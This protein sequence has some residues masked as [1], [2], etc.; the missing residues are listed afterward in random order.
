MGICSEPIGIDAENDDMIKVTI[1]I[2]LFQDDTH[3]NECYSSIYNNFNQKIKNKFGTN[4]LTVPQ[5]NELIK[6]YGLNSYKIYGYFTTERINPIRDFLKNIID[7][8]EGLK[9]VT[10]HWYCSDENV[11]YYFEY[12][13]END[14]YKF[15]VYTG[16]RHHVAYTK[17]VYPGDDEYDD[18]YSEDDEEQYIFDVERY[19]QNFRNLDLDYE[20]L[21]TGL[22]SRRE[23][24]N[25]FLFCQ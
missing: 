24:W 14:D 1:D 4:L 15:G 20:D 23:I 3:Y 10:Y 12:V 19:K 11:P 5:F 2:N 9:E 17:V 25:D 7:Q 6:E 22:M 13:K 21:K 18:G 8:N 16:N